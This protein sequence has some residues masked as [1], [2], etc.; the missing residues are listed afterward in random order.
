M[1]VKATRNRVQADCTNRQI[2]NTPSHN[3]MLPKREAPTWSLSLAG[4]EWPDY[5]DPDPDLSKAVIGDV[6]TTFFTRTAQRE[7]ESVWRRT[8]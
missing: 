3:T 6:R 2:R 5:L 7:L 1:S 8:V 4:R